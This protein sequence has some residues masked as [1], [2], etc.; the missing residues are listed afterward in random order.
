MQLYVFGLSHYCEKAHWTLDYK[1]ADYRLVRLLPGPHFFQVRRFAA[2]TTV[3]VVVDGSEVVQ[4]SDRIIDY[5]D[6]RIQERPLTPTNATACKEARAWEARFDE[7]VGKPVRRIIYFHVLA[8]QSLVVPMFTANG[9]WWGRAFYSAGGFA[10]VRRL[11]RSAY[12]IRAE[13]VEKDV[14]T[15][16]RAFDAV[17]ARLSDRPYLVGDSFTRAD[18]TLAA[19][20]APFYPPAEHPFSYPADASLPEGLIELRREFD[21]RPVGDIVRRLYQAHRLPSS[22]QPAASRGRAA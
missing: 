6:A 10:T 19:L 17:E 18:L 2:R 5:L 15:L 8:R 20:A 11:I 7:E 16:R 22:E 3:P 21:D 1:R 12:A 13:T 14:V 4:G 9:P